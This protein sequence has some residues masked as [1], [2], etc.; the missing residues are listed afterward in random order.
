ML[1]LPSCPHRKYMQDATD[2]GANRP[3]FGLACAVLAFEVAI[4][5]CHMRMSHARNTLY[6]APM[7]M[8]LILAASLAM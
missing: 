6:S 5:S 7:W 8:T 4:S 1:S 3:A 2:S